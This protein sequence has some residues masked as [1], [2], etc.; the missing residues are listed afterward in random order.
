MSSVISPGDELIVLRILVR[1]R[2]IGFLRFD[3]F[4]RLVGGR[5]ADGP[6]GQDETGGGGGILCRHQAAALQ[7]CQRSRSLQREEAGT[8][9]ADAQ[10]NRTGAERLGYLC[11]N[12][13]ES[14]PF[15]ERL[16]SAGIADVE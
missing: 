2:G 15:T 13:G 9:A 6:R 11:W 4:L 8:Q 16:D 3:G 7:G 12:R 14:H 5:K 10:R 1:C